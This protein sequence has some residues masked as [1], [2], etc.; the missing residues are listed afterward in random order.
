MTDLTLA[1]AQVIV[2]HAL[3]AGRAAGLQPL[4]V[5]VLDSGGH[6]K[7]FAREDTSAIL[8]PQIAVGK[9]WSALGLGRG[10]RSLSEKSPSFL[11]SLAAMSE[12]KVVPSPGGVLVRDAS[13]AVIGA[14]G[15]TGDTGDNDEACAVAGI[16]AAGLTADGG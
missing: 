15:I 12:G 3:A 14:V 1:H 9:A 10:T 4:T 16:E 13:G 6:L 11:A 2:E 8:R 5:A 7:A